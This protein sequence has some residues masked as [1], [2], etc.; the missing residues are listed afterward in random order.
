MTSSV[1]LFAGFGHA[2]ASLLVGDGAES[3]EVVALTTQLLAVAACFQWFDGTQNIAIGSLRGLKHTRVSLIAAIVGYWVVGLPAA[4]LLAGTS[5]GPMG[6]W[7][8]L[9]LALATTATIL[10]AS[11]EIATT[12][13]RDPTGDVRA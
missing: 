13:G 1:V 12:P 7:W 10:V 6:V 8:G 11:F 9:V 3:A 2:I 4:W 5:L